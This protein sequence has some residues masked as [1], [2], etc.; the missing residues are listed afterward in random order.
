MMKMNR[1][2]MA[3]L[4]CLAMGSAIAGEEKVV[5]KEGPGV[6][7]V[8]QNCIACHSLDYI[9]MNSPFLDQKGWEAVVAKMAG[10]F[11]A[12][13]KEED[14]KPIADYLARYYGKK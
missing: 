6:D 14:R 5:L 8:R 11:K 12:P 7:K 2:S 3:V 10:P 13:I 1:A 4:A 9:P